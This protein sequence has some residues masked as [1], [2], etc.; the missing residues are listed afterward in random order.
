MKIKHLAAILL[1]FSLCMSAPVFAQEPANPAEPAKTEVVVEPAAE[2]PAKP[3]APVVEETKPVDAPE[4]AKAE[5]TKEVSEENPLSLLAQL[6]EAWKGGK[7]NLV[8]STI[9]MLL[10][11][12]FRTFIMKSLSKEK[13]AY[14]SIVTAVAGSLAISLGAGL[15]WLDAGLQG[16]MVGLSASGLWSAGGKK[17]LPAK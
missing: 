4:G 10:L 9:L 17:V 15:G 7:W 14:L 16:L 13:M 2:V 11:W 8:V 5:D 6:V 12:G 3:E 1:A